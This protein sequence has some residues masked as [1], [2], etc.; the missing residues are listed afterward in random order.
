MR[1]HGGD[2]LVTRVPGRSLLG[3]H[4]VTALLARCGPELLAGFVE[5]ASSLE[6]V[7]L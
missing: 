1:G 2:P 5:L 4:S 6:V 3:Y 7:G